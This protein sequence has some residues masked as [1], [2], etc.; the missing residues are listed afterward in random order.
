METGTN[1]NRREDRRPPLVAVLGPT[2]TGKTMLGVRLAERLHGEIVSCDSMQIYRG[3]PVGTAQPTA[4]ELR[5]VPCHLTA[6]VP[7][8]RDFSVSDFVREATG[9][10]ED[11]LRRGKLPILVGGTGLYAR[12]FLRGFDFKDEAR[13]DTLRAALFARAEREGPDALYETL[14]RED[15]QAAEGIHP[16]NVKRVIR[17]LEYIA[18]TGEPFSRQAERYEKAQGRYRA[19]VFCLMFRDRENLYRRIDERVDA[20]MQAGLLEEARML[21][22]LTRDG[23]L[24]APTAAQAIGYKEFFPYFEGM[25]TLAEAVEQVKRE[26][27]RYAKRQITWF[28]REPET[29]FIYWEDF[30]FAEEL[31]T[32]CVHSVREFLDAGG[33]AA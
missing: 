15:P 4:E 26:S 8:E 12:S 22:A 31:V 5:G 30:A 10:A 9:A 11:I 32:H 2:A 21:F 29:E 33:G 1:I 16:H 25:C 6:Y 28:L 13:D 19:K 18:L 3:L 14:Y 17:A 20:M 7:I 27:R 23:K 24:R